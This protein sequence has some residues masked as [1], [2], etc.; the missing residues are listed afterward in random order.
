MEENISNLQE[1]LYNLLDEYSELKDLFVL[2][3]T[4]K[5]QLKEKLKEKRILKRSFIKNNL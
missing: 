4:N 5:I 3:K 2:L 1:K